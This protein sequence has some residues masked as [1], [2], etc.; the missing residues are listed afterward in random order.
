MHADRPVAGAGAVGADRKWRRRLESVTLAGRPKPLLEYF[1][2]KRFHRLPRPLV[3][4]F[5]VCRAPGGV[6]A[7]AMVPLDTKERA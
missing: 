4:R 2:E 6:A 1:G 3:G 5:V 7:R